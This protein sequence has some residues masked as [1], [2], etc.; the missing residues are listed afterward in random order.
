M[1]S[2]HNDVTLTVS[3]IMQNIPRLKH[4]I[5]YPDVA[6]LSVKDVFW[7]VVFRSGKILLTLLVVKP[8]L[9]PVSGIR[10]LKYVWW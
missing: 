1:R 9:I 6:L 4:K 7:C 2:G 5:N 8:A 3:I 10:L